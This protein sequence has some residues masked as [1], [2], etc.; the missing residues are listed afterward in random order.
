MTSLAKRLEKQLNNLGLPKPF[1]LGDIP[2]VPTS[3]VVIRRDIRELPLEEQQRVCDAIEKMMEPG[4]AADSRN[5]TGGFDDEASPSEYFR[6]ARYHGWDKSYCPRG[7][8]TF[9]G[10][11][12]GYLVDFER[13]L[14]AAD[15]ALGR[16]GHLALPY[17][18]WERG[19]VAGQLLPRV[20][21][22]RFAALPAPLVQQLQQLGVQGQAEGQAGGQAEG[23]GSG[24]PVL[25][26]ALVAG[27]EGCGYQLPE[28]GALAA[29]MR[30]MQVEA[31]V[32][33][34]LT[35]WEHSRAA[36]C[37]PGLHTAPAAAPAAAPGA[38]APAPAAS[39]EC[40]HTCMLAL[41]GNPLSSGCCCGPS[42][43]SPASSSAAAA[44]AAAAPPAA[45]AA[46]AAFHPL[47]FLLA[48]G[49]D[50]LYEAHLRGRRAPNAAGGEYAP[51]NEFNSRLYRQ[52][53]R[54]FRHPATGEPLTPRHT[55]KTE[56]LGYRYDRL[57]AFPDPRQQQGGQPPTLVRFQAN[58]ATLSGR[59]LALHVFLLPRGPAAGSSP[60]ATTPAT[61]T[62][63]PR[64]E[65]F[66]ALPQYGGAAV[67]V[68]GAEGGQ[69]GDSGRSA[70]P[71]A[72]PVAVAVHSMD[73]SECLRR[74]GLSRHM[75]RV[76]VV[77]VD[78]LSG[79][80]V[81]LGE[82]QLEPQLVGP[83]FASPSLP[84]R[85]VADRGEHS[86][87]EAAE[88]SQLQ[89]YLARYGWYRGGG[90]AGGEAEVEAEAGW[91]GGA[92]EAAVRG[93]QSYLGLEADGEA[94][95]LTRGLMMRPR[96]DDLPDQVGASLPPAPASPA[97]PP[98]AAVRWW[99][100]G[101][102]PY[103]S[104]EAVRDE[105]A[106]VL[107]EWAA[108][109]VALSFLEV[110]IAAE[111]DLLI[112]WASTPPRDPTTRSSS[113]RGPWQELSRTAPR[114]PVHLDPGV[115][116]LLAAAP[117]V[118][119]GFYLRPVLL[120]AIGHALGLPHSSDPRDAMSPLYQPGRVTLAAGDRAAAAA[121]F[122][123][124]PVAEE[125]FSVLDL[126]QDGLISRE[127]FVFAMCRR[128]KK[129]LQRHEAEAVFTEADS[130]GWGALTADQF[131][132][133]LARLYFGE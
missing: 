30:A 68:P 64:P 133:L 120:H 43:S 103:L 74:Q 125:M 61:F 100:G 1:P 33:A 112:T 86:E 46:L 108:G 44:A 8:E 104:G 85:R 47:L 17:W 127:E 11:H 58:P 117:A 80:Q 31:Q 9:P 55:F 59:P 16:D 37:R 93:F 39:L 123:V 62:P 45:P 107:A 95:P 35:A 89:A 105:V 24:G 67:L 38:P 126:N 66:P 18:G 73:V 77:A 20:V 15:R 53:L 76:E 106:G 10:W 52:P 124:Q 109:G 101:C 27:A 122:P 75:A 83:L 78:L 116:W 118:P 94:G 132:Q 63:P 6:L 2:S 130:C 51:W 121:L 40:V 13:T 49:S 131:Q 48:A 57:P 65:D 56:A 113:P 26:E 81:E 82:G 119:G 32:A 71:D 98:G 70:G 115:Q 96:V 88:V 50:R 84:L 5:K 28:E 54:P 111:A 21:R 87:E 25:L 69:A 19:P 92:T 90:G 22:E 23:G 60:T 102:P 97:F 29:G 7:L 114:G 91:F 72:V 12:R 3:D 110:P 99:A 128:G 129:L 4:W 41:C 79:R 34:A 36:C 14:Q 42:S